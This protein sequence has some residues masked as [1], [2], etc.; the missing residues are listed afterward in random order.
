MILSNCSIGHD[1][2]I[3]EN[4]FLA[5]GCHLLGNVSIGKNCLIGAG[6]VIYPN[7]RLSDDVVTGINS[8][9]IMSIEKGETFVPPP[10]RKIRRE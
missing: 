2:F 5:P 10:S 7:T 6:S 3:G 1:T 8:S 9:I 4:C